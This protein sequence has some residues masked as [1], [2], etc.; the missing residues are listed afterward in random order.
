MR[1]NQVFLAEYEFAIFFLSTNCPDW[2]IELLSF[3]SEEYKVYDR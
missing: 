3:W 1:M 2:L